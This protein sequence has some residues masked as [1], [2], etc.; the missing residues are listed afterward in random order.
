MLQVPNLNLTRFEQLSD[1][2]SDGEF[3]P[4]PEYEDI[5]TKHPVSGEDDTRSLL[6]RRTPNGIIAYDIKAR[7]S[8]VDRPNIQMPLSPKD[9]LDE[10]HRD[11]EK[12][13]EFGTLHID[14]V[15]FL[16]SPTYPAQKY[17]NEEYTL[18]VPSTALRFDSKFESGNLA[19]A[20]MV[21]VR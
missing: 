15:K 17:L 2:S 20:V 6:F 18:V 7:Y 19:R 3:V 11:T 8:D 21:R 12:C 16:T 13:P 1:I 14:R 9:F 5:T 10:I 4:N